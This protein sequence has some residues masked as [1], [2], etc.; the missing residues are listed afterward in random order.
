VMQLL[1]CGVN[2]QS[3][4]TQASTWLRMVLK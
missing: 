2:A 3:K 4:Y 1:F